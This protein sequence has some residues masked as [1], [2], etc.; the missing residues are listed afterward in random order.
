MAYDALKT[1]AFVAFV[2]A[3][4]AAINSIPDSCHAIV[5]WGSL[6]GEPGSFQD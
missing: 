2:T 3:Q 6:P 5:Q 4:K 1:A